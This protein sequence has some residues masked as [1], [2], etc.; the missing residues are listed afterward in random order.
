MI[1]NRAVEEIQRL[2]SDILTTVTKLL[3]THNALSAT[4]ND[5]CASRRSLI[6]GRRNDLQYHM[7]TVWQ[8]AFK[9]LNE[10]PP[11]PTFE[12]VDENFDLLSHSDDNSPINLDDGS[13]DSD[14][15]FD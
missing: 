15:S 13:S 4:A 14:E 3:R 1:R 10:V 7:R 2:K 12:C 5:T 6:L 11:L 8:V 9:Y